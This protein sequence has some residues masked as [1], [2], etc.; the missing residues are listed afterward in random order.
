VK[1]NFFKLADKALE[2]QEMF[3]CIWQD[4][5]GVALHL[6]FPFPHVT[7]YI[8]QDEQGNLPPLNVSMK[9]DRLT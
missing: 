2:C 1:G 6:S 8:G 7:L 3:V 4:S 5:S 9:L